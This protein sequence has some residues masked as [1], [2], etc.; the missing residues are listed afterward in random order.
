M[1]EEHPAGA[2]TERRII[3][4]HDDDDRRLDERGML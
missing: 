3:V 4:T 1:D 2:W